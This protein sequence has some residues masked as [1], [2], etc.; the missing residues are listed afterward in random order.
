M[1]FRCWTAWGLI[2]LLFVFLL[3]KNLTPYSETTSEN[4][5]E[6]AHIH[7]FL[8][9]TAPSSQAE[10]SSGQDCHSAQSIFTASALPVEFHLQPFNLPR[11]SFAW[12]FSLQT[13]FPSP[14][15]SP[16]RRPPRV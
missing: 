1:N 7:R 13:D 12:V 16:L 11:I 15:I 2:I 10:A 4:C 3:V 5:G 6:F 14:D 9:S 8:W